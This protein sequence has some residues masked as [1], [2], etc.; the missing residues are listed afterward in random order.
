MAEH[1]DH[2]VDNYLTWLQHNQGR[3]VATAV[4]YRGHLERFAAWFEDPP[5]DPKFQPQGRDP[6]TAEPTDL[7]LYAGLVSHARK[8]TAS[9][10]R[11][12]VSALRG[13]YAW[14][15]RNGHIAGNVAADLPQPKAGSPLPRPALLHEAE[16]LLMAPDIGTFLGLRDA[17]MLMLLM[18]CGIRVSGLCGMNESA[19][20][21]TF[22]Q[23]DRERLNIRVTEKGKKERLV[24]APIEVGMLLRAYMGHDELAEI[25]RTLA[26]G[27]AVLFPTTRNRLLLASDYHGAARRMTPAAVRDMIKKHAAAAKI[28]PSVAHPHALRHLYGTEMAEDRVDPLELQ[29]LFGH[30]DLKSTTI[31]TAT[32]KRR[33]RETV[34]R[35]NPL[36]KMRAPILDSLR[37]L[38]R[39]LDGARHARPRPTAVEKSNSR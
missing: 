30:S 28:R 11:P 8:L 29:A 5:D 27:D 31:Y 22:D 32:A 2:L 16:Q 1:F 14:L 24:P 15:A 13:F 10:R 25:P 19:L 4:K 38:G 23:E 9:A 36:A 37:T 7:E 21:W 17:C 33:L 20:E 6:L 39:T 34:D 26:D 12:L 18:G 3:S 35:S